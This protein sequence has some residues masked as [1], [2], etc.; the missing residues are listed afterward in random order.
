MPSKKSE[1]I[2]RQ[3]EAY[4]LMS[5]RCAVCYFPRHLKA[6]R[7]EA[8]LHHLVGRRGGLDAH[9][10]R[11]LICVCTRCHEDYHQGHSQRPLTLGHMLQAKLEEDGEEMFDPVFLAKLLHRAGLKEDAAPLPQWVVEERER[12]ARLLVSRAPYIEERE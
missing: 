1:R 7:R 6:Y 3:L 4:A 9:D 12:N 8:Q 11:N 5:E 2:H 10:H